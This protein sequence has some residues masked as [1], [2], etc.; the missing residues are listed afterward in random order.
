[1]SGDTE[2]HD[3]TTLVMQV[4]EHEQEPERCSWGD[5]EIN[6]CQP[7]EWLRRNV[8]WVG[9]GGLERRAMSF[10]TTFLPQ[11]I[12]RRKNPGSAVGRYVP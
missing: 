7:P 9:D 8:R 12:M 3:P 6:G 11:N 1:M 5:E 2:M 10:K 4:D